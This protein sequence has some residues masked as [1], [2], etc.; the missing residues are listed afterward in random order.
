MQED[1]DRG[2]VNITVKA[3]KLTGRVLAKAMMFAL[4]KMKEAHKN[5]QT[6]QGRQSVEKLMN[7]R[8]P[9]NALPLDGST[10]LFD[11]IARKHNVDYA[12]HKIEPKKYLL[13]FKA[14]QADSITHCFAEY[15]KQ[16][17]QNAKD[18]KPS[19]LN[20]LNKLGEREHT[21]PKTH[22]RKREA[23]RDDR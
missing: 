12:F 3:T 2:T 20:M 9:T 8:V 22:E 21:K 5:A 23:M 18:K 6:P 10:E 16:V 14:G 15:T 7:H 1:I 11:R 4:Q 17:M 13:F 19:I